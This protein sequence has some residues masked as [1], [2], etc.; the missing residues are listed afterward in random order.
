MMLKCVGISLFFVP[1]FVFIL[2][3]S[4]PAEQMAQ[5]C[6]E[7]LCFD[8]GCTLMENICDEV[9]DCDDGSDEW[10]CEEMI[11]GYRNQYFSC[12]TYKCL[13]NEFI[14][15]AN[16]DCDD[17]TDEKHCDYIREQ[18]S[19]MISSAL[20]VAEFHQDHGII[21]ALKDQSL[22]RLDELRRQ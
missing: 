18:E 10:N 19:E 1:L 16:Q 12:D 17:N 13:P 14:C 5:N 8:G 20:P 22:E 3:E 4:F 2:V 21:E 9:E 6:S 7:Y 11:C 15:D